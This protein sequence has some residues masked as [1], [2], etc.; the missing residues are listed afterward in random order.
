MLFSLEVSATAPPR[1][2]FTKAP[3]IKF[4]PATPPNHCEHT[5]KLEAARMMCKC[6]SKHLQA[7][8]SK[9]IATSQALLQRTWSC[10]CQKVS[11]SLTGGTSGHT[12]TGLRE[13]YIFLR[14]EMRPSQYQHSVVSKCSHMN[15]HG[16]GTLCLCSFTLSKGTST[17]H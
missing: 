9:L 16:T 5:I 10:H 8:I 2:V 11:I 15:I 17:T 7:P 13:P 14:P 12:A 4:V 3:P 6:Q 1:G